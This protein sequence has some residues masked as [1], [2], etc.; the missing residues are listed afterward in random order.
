MSVARPRTVLM[1]ACAAP[2]LVL[3]ALYAVQPQDKPVRTERVFTE[4][5]GP[6]PSLPEMMNAAEAVARVRLERERPHDRQFAHEVGPRVM[7]L[8]T[9]VVLEVFKN[10]A[11]HPLVEGEGIGV[12]RQGGRR[13]RGQHIEDVVQDGFPPFH[14]GE[15]VLFLRWHPDYAGWVSAFG[16]DGAY[17]IEGAQVG[18]LGSRPVSKAQHGRPAEEFLGDLRRGARLGPG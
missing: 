5:F 17:A 13:D 12:I 18:S 9:G 7:T 2:L 6:P 14:H 4:F 11:T 3:C 8:H 1:M 10:D 15:Y 16:P